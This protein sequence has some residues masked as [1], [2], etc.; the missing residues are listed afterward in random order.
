[1]TFAALFRDR[2]VRLRAEERKDGPARERGDNFLHLSALLSSGELVGRLAGTL[3]AVKHTYTG[4]VLA[5][6]LVILALMVGTFLVVSRARTGGPSNP[7][8]VVTLVVL[9]YAAFTALLMIE[10]VSLI[11]LVLTYAAA[12]VAAASIVWL[13]RKPT[14]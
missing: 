6:L 2:E 14:T 10:G 8:R 11:A 12:T 7:I 4:R 9:N 5:S 3:K 1:V 13:M